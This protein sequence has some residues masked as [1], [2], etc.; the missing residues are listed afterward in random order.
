MCGGGGGELMWA[1]RSAPPPQSFSAC[2][3]PVIPYASRCSR[4]Q[5]EEG[6]GEG[7]GKP[8]GDGE[9]IMRIILGK[10]FRRSDKTEKAPSAKAKN[11]SND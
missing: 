3:G 7:K 11:T 6:R 8:E 5:K 9:K 10:I 4:F 1:T 2:Y